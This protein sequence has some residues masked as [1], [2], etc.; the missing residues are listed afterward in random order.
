MSP[1]LFLLLPTAFLSL[2]PIFMLPYSHH[3]LLSPLSRPPRF[4]TV[5][6]VR[7]AQDKARANDE[8][9]LG[10]VKEL[11]KRYHDEM[12]VKEQVMLRVSGPMLH[13]P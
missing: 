11:D 7:A 13:L 6:A 10:A 8:V 5:E 12:D 4:A 2:N 3:P 1:I 9:I